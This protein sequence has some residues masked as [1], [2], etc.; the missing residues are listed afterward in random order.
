MGVSSPY[1][2]LSVLA[3]SW[4]AWIDGSERSFSSCTCSAVRSASR[5]NIAYLPIFGLTVVGQAK[6]FPSRPLPEGNGVL[7]WLLAVRRFLAKPAL[8]PGD[9]AAGVQ[10]LLLARVERVAARA[11]VGVDDAVLGGAAGG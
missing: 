8:E 10:D 2:R 5:S 6:P 4:S 1:R 9:A 11:D 3:R 7:A